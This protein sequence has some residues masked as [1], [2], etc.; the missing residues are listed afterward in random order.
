MQYP[1]AECSRFQQVSQEENV[2]F[3]CKGQK[4][5]IW[6][7]NVFFAH[8]NG[9][10]VTR[11][12]PRDQAQHLVTSSKNYIY[13]LCACHLLSA[14][15]GQQEAR[16]SPFQTE[17]L[18]REGG[19][20]T[21][22]TRNACS[23]LMFLRPT[24]PYSLGHGTQSSWEW[25]VQ[26]AGISQHIPRPLSFPGERRQT[27][28]QGGGRSETLGEGLID[29]KPEGTGFQI[30]PDC[31]IF[32][33]ALFIPFTCQPGRQTSFRLAVKGYGE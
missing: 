24:H 2:D 6:T 15:R 10:H 33:S 8:L 16:G 5:L 1:E 11:A 12:C 27:W 30:F 23:P 19:S 7:I 29:E 17:M 9:T 26:D 21:A 28:R 18:L 13:V 31:S 22:W 32:S 14:A 20:Q 3:H 25:C 4:P